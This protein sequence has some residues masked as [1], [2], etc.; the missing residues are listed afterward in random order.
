MC[1]SKISSIKIYSNR[2]VGDS[3]N[4]YH[5]VYCYFNREIIL[6]SVLL[7]V[8]VLFGNGARYTNALFNLFGAL[9]INNQRV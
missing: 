9:N 4:A 6:G 3:Y 2:T 8:N 5:I 7:S 1:S